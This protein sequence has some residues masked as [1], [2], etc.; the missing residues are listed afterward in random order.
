MTIK[1]WIQVARHK[2]DKVV[3][4]DWRFHNEAEVMEVRK[5]LNEIEELVDEQSGKTT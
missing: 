5:A 4:T 3:V 1:E 2:L